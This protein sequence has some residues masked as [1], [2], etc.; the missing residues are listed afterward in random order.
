M[1]LSEY[2]GTL[3]SELA[4]ITQIAGDEVARA[5]DLLAGTL[6]PL[7]RLILL[8]V[9]SAA[10]AEITDRLDGTVVEIRLPGGEPSFVVQAEP[11]IPEGPGQPAAPGETAEAGTARITLRLSEG[12]KTR[13]EAAAASEGVSVNGWLAHAA[14]RALEA[15]PGGAPPSRPGLGRRI[16]GFARS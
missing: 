14:R 4:T 10:A 2:I 16:T 6:E 11:G 8:D 7:V 5:A 1:E 12:L 13:V 9:L 15:P 3:R